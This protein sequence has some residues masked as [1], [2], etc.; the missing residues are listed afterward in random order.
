[1]TALAMIMTVSLGTLSGCGAK[2]EVDEVTKVDVDVS[3]PSVKELHQ[4]GNFIGTIE[5]DGKVAITP[6]ISGLVTTRNFKVGDY[7]KLI[8]DYEKNPIMD[9]CR[10]PDNLRLDGA[11][12]LQRQR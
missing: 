12:I 10:H 2:E 11:N 4:N 9:I 3:S 7:V 8:C 6:R 5:S 1:M